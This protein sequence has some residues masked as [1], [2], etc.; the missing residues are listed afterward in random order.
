VTPEALWEW[1]DAAGLPFREPVPTLVVR[2]GSVPEVWTTA[3]SR[4]LLT[5]GR[6]LLDGLDG[7]VFARVIE[8]PDPYRPVPSLHGRV[9]GSDAAANLEVLTRQLATRFGPGRET[10]VSN[11]KE[12]TWGGGHCRIVARIFPRHLNPDRG[13]HRHA[14]D[15]GSATEATIEIRPD[16]WPPMSEADR[17][18]IADYH[19]R[20]EPPVFIAE[21][22]SLSRPAPAEARPGCG[23]SCDGLAMV[24]V[25]ADGRCL[26]V[27][28]ARITGV[29]YDRLRPAKGGGSSEVALRLRPFGPESLERRV[30]LVEGP[31]PSPGHDA[32]AGWA[33]D[34]FGVPLSESEFDDV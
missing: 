14:V 31:F 8:T 22:D 18:S 29:S 24:W 23:P 34:E 2:F 17:A 20:L 32:I 4:C 1:L 25:S 9:R 3:V 30:R 5:G 16:W 27:P 11:T 33:R 21:Y 7:P 26:V 19:A 12:W 15:P 28:R 6:P 13:N 10:S